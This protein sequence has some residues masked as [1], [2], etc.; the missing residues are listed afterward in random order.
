MMDVTGLLCV[1]PHNPA[2][3]QDAI[4]QKIERRWYSGRKKGGLAIFRGERR[5]E[6]R[7]W[8]EEISPAVVPH[9]ALATPIEGWPYTDD[10]LVVFIAVGIWYNF[11]GGEGRTEFVYQISRRPPEGGIHGVIARGAGVLNPTDLDCRRSDLGDK[12]S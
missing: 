12:A 11:V 7:S 3:A 4:L 1:Y 9:P 6:I 8:D 10:D 5:V 2:W